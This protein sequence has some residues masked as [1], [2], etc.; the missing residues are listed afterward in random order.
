MEKPKT[1]SDIRHERFLKEAAIAKEMAKQALAEIDEALEEHYTPSIINYELILGQAVMRGEIDA[2]EALTAS[3][4]YEAWALHGKPGS[5]PITDDDPLASP[6][7]YYQ[8]PE[9]IID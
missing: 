8:P 6:I 5:I 9:S 1:Y 3:G 7:G 2:S 4:N